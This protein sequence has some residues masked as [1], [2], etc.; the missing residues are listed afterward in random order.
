MNLKFQVGSIEKGIRS[1]DDNTSFHESALVILGECFET[2]EAEVIV[3]GMPDSGM[4]QAR[5]S[6]QYFEEYRHHSTF[7]DFYARADLFAREY[8]KGMGLTEEAT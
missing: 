2:L 6:L 7:S 3:S 5:L 4:G 1:R 8:C